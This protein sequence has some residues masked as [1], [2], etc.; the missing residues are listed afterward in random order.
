VGSRRRRYAALAVALALG[1]CTVG[2]P[3]GFSGGDS[4]TIP[5]V[6][7]L[8]DGLLLV[9]ALVNNRGPYVFAIDPDAHVSIVDQDV[10][11]DTGARV[12]E[13]PHL[14]DETDT[15]QPRF[16]AEIL[17]WQLGTLNV[18][19][20]RS[21]QIVPAGTFD[22]DGRRIHGVIG[23]DIIADSLVFSFDRD[24][25]VVTLTTTKS[26]K[27]GVTVPIKYSVLRSRIDNAEV[28]P[29]SRRLV[30]ASLGGH[31]YALHVDLGAIPSQLRARSWASA[32]LAESDAPLTLVDEVGMPRNVTKRGV[33]SSVSVGAVSTPSV[34]F[35]P[36]YDRRWPDQDL[37]GTLGLSFFKPYKVSV[38]WDS[39]TI[40]V[41]PRHTP[42]G[43][44]E[45]RASR[46]QSKTLASCEHLGCIKTALID[47]LA[48]RQPGELPAQHPGLVASFTRDSVAKDLNLEVL[49]AA[50]A[51]DKDL[52]WLVVNLPAGTDRAMTH[53][54]ADYIGA[55]MIVL[56]VGFFPRACPTDGGCVDLVLAPQHVDAPPHPYVA[57]KSLVRRTGEKAIVPDD[58]TK[59]E[60]YDKRIW[61]VGVDVQVCID[62]KGA[63]ES[64]RFLSPSGF[65]A[66]DRKIEST[67]KNTW[68]FDPVVADGAPTAACAVIVFLYTQNPPK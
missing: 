34:A 61:Q 16:F 31:R 5:L 33:A 64:V 58:A 28:L 25:G 41:K 49:I 50:A 62:D 59:A 20:P 15:Q 55:S 39:S 4:W 35:V 54:S 44:F 24:A 56:D 14:L 36:Y 46:W 53:L 60:I 17:D 19:G 52:K 1:G 18:K 42:L 63:V 68:T 32:Q 48:G 38:N 2:A 21:A 40:Y 47:P 22:A 8:E 23:R 57:S 7:P 6:G 29:I 67:I 12:G 13:G 11:K 43:G 27:P 66:Y 51:P 30:T 45:I 26:F 10:V 37:E 3:P 65:P 9:P